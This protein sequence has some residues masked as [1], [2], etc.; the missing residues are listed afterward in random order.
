MRIHAGTHKLVHG[1]LLWEYM[2]EYVAENTGRRQHSRLFISIIRCASAE[3]RSIYNGQ[4]QKF[5]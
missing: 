5:D 2:S 1:D 3:E 4:T